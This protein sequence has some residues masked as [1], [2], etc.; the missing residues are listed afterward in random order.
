MDV[1]GETVFH[2]SAR[3]ISDSAPMLNDF[4]KLNPPFEKYDEAMLEKHFATAD[5]LKAVIYE[6]AEWPQALRKLKARKFNN[7]SFSKTSFS[8]VTLTN[9]NFEDCL[10]I[11]CYFQEVEF[12]DSIEFDKQYKKRYANIPVGLYQALLDNSSN[13]YQADFLMAADIRFCRWK[14]AQ[15]AYDQKEKKISVYRAKWEYLKSWLYEHVAGFGYR[16]GR[17]FM[18]TICLFLLVSVINHCVLRG[19]ISGNGGGGPVTSFADSVFY[20]F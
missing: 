16:P 3:S 6:P 5:H 9:C 2:M 17:F 18:C 13:M 19:S 14:R 15:L 12:T 4:F 1:C 20:S 11:G 7:V 8:R 10:F